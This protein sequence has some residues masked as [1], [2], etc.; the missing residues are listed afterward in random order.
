MSEYTEAAEKFLTDTGTTLTIEFQYT[1]P[2]FAGDKDK[3]DVYRFTL[4]NARGEYSSTFG[5]SI[6]NTERRAF[7]AMIGQG[8]AYW[9]KEAARMGFRKEAGSETISRKSLAE[10]RNYRPSAYDILACL[11]KYEPDTFDNWAAEMGYNDRPLS[12]YPNV[13]KVWTACVEQY[14]GLSRMFS[15]DEME[16]LREI[17]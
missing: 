5:D 1:G 11:E 4:K 8:W 14:R 7:A 17:N 13:L 16:Q 2:Y 6:R 9:S 12:E 10:A 3:R 15:A